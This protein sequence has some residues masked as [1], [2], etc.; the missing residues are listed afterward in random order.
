MDDVV[1]VTAR[2]TITAAVVVVVKRD[3]VDV[4]GSFEELVVLETRSAK[5]A[6]AEEDVIP[7]LDVVVAADELDTEV[8]A[9]E[10]AE[11]EV[12]LAELEA[13]V[14]EAEVVDDVDRLLS[15]DTTPANNVIVNPSVGTTLAML[16]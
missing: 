15:W 4:E 2:S 7:V 14:L 11:D 16:R 6:T 5:S 10:P 13:V 8:V 12:T 3:D 1:D 9:V